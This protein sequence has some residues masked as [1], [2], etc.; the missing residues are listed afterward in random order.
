MTSAPRASAHCAAAAQL[1]SSTGVSLL[2]SSVLARM[3]VALKA[4]PMR[5]PGAYPPRTDRVIVP[6][7]PSPRSLPLATSSSPLTKS[8]RSTMDM[9]AKASW[10]SVSKPV[11]NT[12]TITPSPCRPSSCTAGTPIWLSWP[13]EGP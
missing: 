11:S 8:C 6:W 5:W 12:A 9:A 3:K 2:V 7:L 13:A 4:G 1:S 10:A